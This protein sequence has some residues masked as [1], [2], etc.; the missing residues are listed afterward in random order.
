MYCGV[1]KS[2]SPAPNPIT[3]R[4]AALS[5]LALAS[6][7]RVADSAI[8]A[9]RVAI[10]GRPGGRDGWLT[11]PYWQRSPRWSCAFP[12]PGRRSTHD[13]GARTLLSLIHIS[14]PTR[15]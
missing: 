7:A 1:G 4:P 8:A 5:C 10:L 9:I 6:T 14:E 11:G 15:L 3:G 13:L 2:G 12:R